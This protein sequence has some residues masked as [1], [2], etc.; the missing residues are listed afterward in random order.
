MDVDVIQYCKR[1]IPLLW[2]TSI[3]LFDIIGKY[4]RVFHSFC[5]IEV[6]DRRRP[7]VEFLPGPTSH[8]PYYAASSAMAIELSIEIPEEEKELRELRRDGMEGG[9][10]GGDGREELRTLW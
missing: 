10:E 5:F 4:G 9:L 2:W 3:E 6:L 1:N 8:L 7:P